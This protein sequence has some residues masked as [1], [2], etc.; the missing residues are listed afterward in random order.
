MYWP[1][2]QGRRSKTRLG[3]ADKDLGLHHVFVINLLRSYLRKLSSQR[4]GMRHINATRHSLLLFIFSILSSQ[5]LH[6]AAFRQCVSH[7]SFSSLKIPNLSNKHFQQTKGN[8]S[9]RQTRDTTTKT[10]IAYGNSIWPA[11]KYKVNKL[12][13]RFILKKGCSQCLTYPPFQAHSATQVCT[14]IR[15]NQ[16][17]LFKAG[18]GP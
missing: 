12:H 4:K 13:Q 3:Y 15:Q 16:F 17:F 6:S 11:S 18:H 10:W 1:S 8:N 2:R 7:T 9:A 5:A 14:G